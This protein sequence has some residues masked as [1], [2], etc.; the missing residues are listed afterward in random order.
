M[1]K[2]ILFSAIVA[3]TFSNLIAQNPTKF[4]AIDN[5][6]NTFEI[7]PSNCTSTALNRCTSSSP[8]SIALINNMVYYTVGFDLFRYQFNTIG[9]CQ[10]LGTFNYSGSSFLSS[11]TSGPDGMIYAAA[12][13]TILRYN[14][15]TN[16]FSNLGNIPSQW[17]SSGDLVFFE[18]QLL[19]STINDKL[20]RIDLN[21]LSN[22][23]VILSFASNTNIFGLSTVT[24]PCGNNQLFAINSSG[25]NTTLLPINLTTNTVGAATCSF[26]FQIYDTASLAENGSSSNIIPTFTQ[27]A[28]IC[29]G[30][31]LAALPTTS[32]N[33]INGTWSPAI[34]NTAT[35]TYTF[36]PT[37]GQ[38]ATTT[39]MTI[40]VDN[41]SILHITK[42]DPNCDPS[43]LNWGSLNTISATVAT[44]TLGTNAITINKPTG[45][46][47][48][49]SSVFNGS[50]FPAQFNLP[51]NS[52]SLANF[53]AGLFTFCF[54]TPVV[55]PQ[56]AIA[57]IGQSGLPVPI[58]TSVPYQ[59][60]WSGPGMSFINNQSLIG[61][62]GFCIIV[63]PGTHQ[64]I[65]FDYLTAE[66]WCNIVF[67][68]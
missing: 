63:F 57:S 45:G 52:P 42:D 61:E 22:S 37:T 60:L 35:T 26:P 9:S 47:F 44:T 46:L 28:P 43:Q 11:L 53:E 55:N 68:F 31:P 54:D 36:T 7:D 10:F 58:N 50:I 13:N 34:N 18:G 29:S 27:V 8:F 41:P 32:I 62:E 17:Q 65:S 5:N 40:T 25:G 49:T 20:V 30:A 33:S 12:G 14:P 4:I 2:K 66:N 21:N 67:F 1:F 6:G 15:T 19:L 16:V 23:Q 3:F 59:V 56:I 24:P 48:S 51:I 64:C 38:C 39:T